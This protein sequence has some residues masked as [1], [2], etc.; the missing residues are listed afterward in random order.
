MSEPLRPGSELAPGYE[1]VAH[2]SRNQALDVY[3]L[4]SAERACRCVGKVVRPDRTDDRAR[5]RLVREGEVLLGLTHPHLV[6]AYELLREPEPVLILE[7]LT[8]E[9]LG[10]LFDESGPLASPD[11]AELGQQLCS[12]LAYL[13]RR[14]WLHLDLKPGNVINDRGV[15]KVL[16]LSLTRPPGPVSPGLGTREYAAPEQAA[17]GEATAATD[18]WGIGVLLYMAA[19][20]RRPFDRGS[21]QFPQLT[22]RAPKVTGLPA[23][24]CAAIDACLEP[25]PCDRPSIDDLATALGPHAHELPAAA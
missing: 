8:G 22:Q 24:L 11:V 13:H 6:R 10:H 15:A 25:H 7:T 14:G 12:A 20:G 21:E 1:V 2:L 9:T 4:H 23:G 17:G 19:A 5:A 16:D 18:V 3:D